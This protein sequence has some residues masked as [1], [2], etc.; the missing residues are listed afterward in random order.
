MVN[1]K[2]GVPLYIQIATILEEDILA[3]KYADGEKLPSENQLC[4]QFNVSRITVR[5]ALLQLE[6]KNLLYSVHG[7]GTY[8]QQERI[9]QSLT[10]INS[11]ASVLAQK[12][13][14]GH[15]KVEQYSKN[16]LPANVKQLFNTD[17]IHRLCLVGYANDL[18]MVYYKSY[19]K[20]YMA[21]QMFTF[22]RKWEEEGRAFSTWDMYSEL[23]MRYLRVE[24]KFTATIVDNQISRMLHVPKGDAVIRMETTVYEKNSVVEYK[25]AYYRA[26]KYSFTVVRDAEV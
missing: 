9:N 21:E 10:E 20:G 3:K 15:T 1:P 11:F 25:I 5:Q 24:Q 13:L 7:K 14:K 17:N 6:Q 22:A 26:D 18:P 4:Q 23:N 16:R 19:I 12:G 8:V 2:S